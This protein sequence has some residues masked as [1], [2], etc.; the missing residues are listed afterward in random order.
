MAGFSECGDVSIK[1]LGNRRGTTN[2]PEATHNR[3]R[4]HVL[5]YPWQVIRDRGTQ[6]Q[7]VRLKAKF[8]HAAAGRWAR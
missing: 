2:A 7:S 8:T 4:V 3:W 6:H 1:P 5:K